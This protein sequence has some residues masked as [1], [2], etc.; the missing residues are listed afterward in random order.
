MPREV[1]NEQQSFASSS[2]RA[3]ARARRGVPTRADT[4]ARFDS[5][6]R[7]GRPRS[8]SA[9]SDAPDRSSLSAASAF[10]R[11][12]HEDT[13][14]FRK[15]GYGDFAMVRL[16]LRIVYSTSYSRVLE[17]RFLT[18]MLSSIFKMDEFLKP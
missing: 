4:A 11:V 17:Y 15:D 7:L 10:F 8:R 12:L 2:A 1:Q 16:T 5:S 6:P 13:A 18:P 9:L 3:R 14:R